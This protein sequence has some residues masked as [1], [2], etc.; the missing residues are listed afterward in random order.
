MAVQAGPEV[1][2]KD[3]RGDTKAISSGINSTN[4]GDR[5]PEGSCKG[6]HSKCREPLG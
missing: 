5:E 2:G 4:I 3:G 1:G 6:A